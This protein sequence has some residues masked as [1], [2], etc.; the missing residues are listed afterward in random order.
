MKGVDM[1]KE[2]SIFAGLALMFVMTSAQAEVKSDAVPVAGAVENAAPAPGKCVSMWDLQDFKD[3]QLNNKISG[4]SALSAKEPFPQPV[5][6]PL[7][8]MRF[9]KNC[10]SFGKCPAIMS[11]GAPYSMITEI[12]PEGI[13]GAYCGGI[14]QAFS[15]LNSGFRISLGQDMKLG[16]EINT[17]KGSENTKYVQS[18]TVLQIGTKYKVEVRFD[19]KTASLFINGQLDN[20]IACPL[21]APCSGDIQIGC[22]SGKDYYFIGIIGSVG[23]YALEAVKDEKK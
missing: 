7:T 16:V 6:E 10:I 4:E 19:G 20:A 9:T 3:G 17:G 1:R 11:S 18:K 14:V 15:Y 21:P 23:F 12:V 5:T 8:G 2:Y 22:A 13:P